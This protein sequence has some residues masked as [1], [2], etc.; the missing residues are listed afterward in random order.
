M[1]LTLPHCPFNS[2]HSGVINNSNMQNERITM[3][4]ETEK[5][6]RATYSPEDNKLRLYVGRV[7]RDEYERLR[8]EGWT[9]TPKQSCDF[10]ATWTPKRRDTALEY[11]D[12][13]E[14]EDMGPE[15]RAVDRA[16]RFGEY[17]DKRL[18]EATGHADRYESGP[19]A[20]GF[21][22]AAR[23]ER[24]AARHDRIAGR[25]CDAWS[26]AEYWQ[27]RT[28]GV[29][30]HAL[31]KSNPGVRMGRIKT[32]EAEQ[33][34]NAA[35]LE[36]YKKRYR[37]WKKIAAMEN[38]EEQTKAA[39]GFTGSESGGW[40]D[41]KH[42]RTGKESC[43]WSH[44][45]D[46]KDPITGA[47]AASMWLARMTDPES[48]AFQN[49]GLMEWARHY[50]LRLAYENQMLEAQGGRA[51]FVEMVPGGFIGGKQIHKVNKSHV[52]G[53][54]VSVQVMGTHTGFTKESGYKKQETRP[55]L[56]TIETERLPEDAYRAPTE[57]ELK[58]FEAAR[59]A[60]KAA[61]PKTPTI[62]LINPT[63]KDAER[64]VALWNERRKAAHEAKN[65]YTSPTAREMHS[66]EFKPCV[67]ERVT[68][69]VYSANSKGAYARAETRGLCR[70]GKLRD[71]DSNLW[72]RDSERYERECGPIVCNIRI[73]GYEA[74]RVLI[75]TDKPQKPLPA[76]VWKKLPVVAEPVNA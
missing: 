1:C 42:P 32:L 49:T 51:A 22:N 40:Y 74:Y 73:A 19:S 24:A 7:P 52:T 59:K 55:C 14:D 27:Q 8:A 38:P 17:R 75:L 29:I 33:R 61:Q 6:G 76:E 39:R 71:K 70:D 37:I 18:N 23:A 62:P 69:A 57:E 26:K 28:A 2:G 43:L 3:N 44:L 4:N 5:T 36:D 65:I 21:Q 35:Y 11:A 64:L 53:R 56:V 20:H 46:E 10:V 54:V 72:S 9:S 63:D 60:K 31:Y 13:I 41:Y 67:I 48:E 34:K 47:E 68:Q 15:E 58:A 66:K 12:L 45:T 25:A 50:E 30:A 16:E